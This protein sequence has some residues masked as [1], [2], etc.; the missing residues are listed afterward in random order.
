MVSLRGSLIKR[1]N[2]ESIPTFWDILVFALLSA[3]EVVVFVKQC[4]HVREVIVLGP[5]LDDT[6]TSTSN[7][8]EPDVETSEIRTNNEKHSKRRLWILRLWQERWIQSE[9]ERD[10]GRDKEIGLENALVE[11][12]LVVFKTLGNVRLGVRLGSES[13]FNLVDNF[14][15]LWR[16]RVR[17][18][19]S[20]RIELWPQSVEEMGNEDD[21]AMSVYGLLDGHLTA[22]K[23]AVEHVVRNAVQQGGLL[24]HLVDGSIGTQAIRV[25][26]VHGDDGIA[27]GEVLHILASE[28]HIVVLGQCAERRAVPRRTVA[29]EPNDNPLFTRGSH[30]KVLNHGTLGGCQFV[31]NF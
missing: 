17:E 31:Q 9:R 15:M 29:A 30:S 11:R 27:I 8:S 10:L 16:D 1:S 12:V 4:S 19:L 7:V 18:Q 6:D 5:G 21:T 2:R 20:K 13:L 22:G 23:L 3:C 26:D 25:V 28:V 14:S 24:G